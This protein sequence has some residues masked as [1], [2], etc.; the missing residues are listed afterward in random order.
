MKFGEF[1]YE[2]PLFVRSKRQKKFIFEIASS[3]VRRNSM[4][5]WENDSPKEHP[6]AFW[7]FCNAV[8]QPDT[9]KNN[10]TNIRAPIIQNRNAN[11]VRGE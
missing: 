7:L 10:L 4:Q 5:I 6:N 9:Q 3:F 1:F 8:L 2:K 11:E